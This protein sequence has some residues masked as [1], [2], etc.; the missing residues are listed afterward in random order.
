MAYNLF[1]PWAQG[2]R[3]KTIVG[4]YGSGKTEIALNMALNAPTENREICLVDL[5]IVN[6]FFRS[7]EQGMRLKDGGVELIAPPYA[8][9]GVDLPVLAAEV[10]SVF[11]RKSLRVVF[12]VG[13]EDAGATALGRFQPEFSLNPSDFYYVVNTYRPYSSNVE[14]IIDM[15][16]RIAGR[17]R[18]QFTGLINNGNMGVET[19]P[20]H[21]LH[22]QAMLEVVSERTGIPIVCACA[23]ESVIEQMPEIAVPLF[24]L[25]RMLM[26][27]WLDL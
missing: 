10:S 9:T 1:S 19:T 3:I 14:Q 5:D 15:M 25:E 21:V 23:I 18:M 24:P 17:A 13:G 8:L 16:A 11:E 2:H 20:K 7:A 4:H 6:P 27:E 22:C 12:D 26:P